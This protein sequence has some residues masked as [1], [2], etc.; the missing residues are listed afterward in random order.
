MSC[1]F[2]KDSVVKTDQ[3]L[4]KIQNVDSFNTINGLKVIVLTKAFNRDGILAKIEKNSISKNVPNNTLYTQ[5]DHKFL[6]SPF[7]MEN[8][9]KIKWEQSP[10]DELLYNILLEQHNYMYVNNVKVETLD[11]ESL[12]GKYWLNRIKTE[13]VN[14]LKELEQT[15]NIL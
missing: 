10:K 12:N 7:E 11:P 9:K 6:L 4:I 8:M 3:G 5:K 15:G 2:R 14:I 1:C 13:A